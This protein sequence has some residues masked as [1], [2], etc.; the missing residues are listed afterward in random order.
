MFWLKTGSK[1]CRF[2]TK[3]IAMSSGRLDVF[4]FS[5]IGV[6]G[7][8]RRPLGGI[9]SV[10][11]TPERFCG[12]GNVARGNIDKVVSSKWGKFQLWVNF[13]FKGHKHNW[14]LP[15]T[16]LFVVCRKYRLKNAFY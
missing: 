9:P 15:L 12:L 7:Y 4:F 3:W 13:P 10:H 1:R 5:F 16:S 14:R 8:H 6:H 11:E 2:K